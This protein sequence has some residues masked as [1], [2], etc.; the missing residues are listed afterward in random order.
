MH[1]YEILFAMGATLFGVVVL[2]LLPWGHLI[3]KRFERHDLNSLQMHRQWRMLFTTMVVSLIVIV[4][5]LTITH[6]V[7]GDAMIEAV[8]NFLQSLD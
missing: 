4:F 3:Q 2:V 5:G 1:A 6:W 7:M 8:M